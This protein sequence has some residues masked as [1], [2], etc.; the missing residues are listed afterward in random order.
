MQPRAQALGGKR[1]RIAAPEER[2]SGCDTLFSH[3]ARDPGWRFGGWCEQHIDPVVAR[4]PGTRRPLCCLSAIHKHATIA[5]RQGWIFL[6]DVKVFL[7]LEKCPFGAK[8]PQVKTWFAAIEIG[9]RT[10]LVA[11]PQLFPMSL[12][13][14]RATCPRNPT[15]SPREFLCWPL[16]YRNCTPGFARARRRTSSPP[17]RSI[18]H[19]RRLR[20]WACLHRKYL[21]LLGRRGFACETSHG[22]EGPL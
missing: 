6:C 21:P 2:K 12:F 20:R 5:R 22:V 4:R 7:S 17:V 10:K 11:F 1:D 14:L 8:Y 18:E 19:R 13:G 16:P 15:G 3:D 9:A